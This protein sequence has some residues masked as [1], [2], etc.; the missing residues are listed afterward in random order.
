MGGLPNE[1]IPIPTYP[2]R[3]TDKMPA[4]KMPGFLFNFNANF[5]AIEK[6]HVL[7][8]KINTNLNNVNVNLIFNA[9]KCCFIKN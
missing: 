9:I 4:D 5:N 1:L 8:L 7:L 2:K 6:V 3:S